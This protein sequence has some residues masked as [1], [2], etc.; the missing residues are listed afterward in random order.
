MDE[1][2]QTDVPSFN[3]NSNQDKDEYSV[4][5]MITLARF[6]H[7]SLLPGKDKLID[8]LRNI[9]PTAFS[10]RAKALRKLDAIAVKHKHP[11]D[12]GYYWEV[13]PDVLDGLGLTDLVVS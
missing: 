7:H 12:T 9:H 10:N 2:D 13:K 6:I 1:E 5:D 3:G 4:E 8:E 11:T